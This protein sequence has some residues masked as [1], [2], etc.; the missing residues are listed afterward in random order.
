MRIL[1]VCRRWWPGLGGIETFVRA[2]ARQ[3]DQAHEVRVVAMRIDNAP[4][5]QLADGPGLPA[6]DEFTDGRVT[7]TPLRLSCADEILLSPLRIP[8]PPLTNS[9]RP[10][11]GRRGLTRLYAGVVA[12]RIAPHVAWADLVH[13]WGLIPGSAA[14][15]RAGVS[16]DKPVVLTPFMH[17]GDWGDDPASIETYRRASLVLALQDPEAEDLRSVGVPAERI[18][19]SGACVG[20]RI[21]PQDVPQVVHPLVLFIGANLPHKGAE[22]LIEAVARLNTELT[23]A[24]A[25]S[26]RKVGPP[27]RAGLATILQLGSVSAGAL[28]GWLSAADLLCLPSSSETFGLVVLEA[29]RE[30][31]PVLVSDIPAL[32]TLVSSSR[33]GATTPVDPGSLAHSLGELLSRPDLLCEMGA[34]GRDH[35]KRN[36]TAERIAGHHLSLYRRCL[37]GI[38]PSL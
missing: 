36:F 30:G 9:R 19:I 32:R 33:G 18:A 24:I 1:Y 26:G 28:T 29:W 5:D 38:P 11:L 14:G 27:R 23:V 20:E 34:A 2:V 17:T 16:G 37:H 35:W 4:F 10:V 31:T 6:F 3:L 13:V 7:V 21:D 12:K 8:R 25:G 15:V 22:A